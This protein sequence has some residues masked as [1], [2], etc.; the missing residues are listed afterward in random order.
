[1]S[2]SESFAALFGYIDIATVCLWTTGF[3]LFAVEYFRPL[4]GL[5][6]SLGITLIGASFITRM[7]HGSPGEAFMFV[8]L[9][10]IVMFVVHIVSLATQK[11]DWLRVAR[12]KKSDG[13]SR[14]YGSLIGKVGVA[15]TPIDHTGNVAIDDINLV[16]YSEKPIPSGARVVITAVTPNR[17]IIEKLDEQE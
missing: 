11:R 4:H 5:M 3:I 9:T 12:I 10:S 8:F 2:P 1:M 17:I 15:N 7:M 6:Y 13:I 16:V 14:R